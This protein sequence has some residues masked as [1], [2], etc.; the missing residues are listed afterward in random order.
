MS[1][2]N[3]IMGDCVTCDNCLDFIVPPRKGVTVPDRYER[4]GFKIMCKP[5]A[6]AELAEWVDEFEAIR[7][8]THTY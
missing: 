4:D 6:E 3:E 1:T 8:G 5:C 7:N 2:T